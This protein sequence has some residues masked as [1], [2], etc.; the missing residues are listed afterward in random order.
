MRDGLDDRLMNIDTGWDRLDRIESLYGKD[1]ARKALHRA[2]NKKAKNARKVPAGYD[3]VLIIVSELFPLHQ[4]YSIWDGLDISPFRAVF[5]A[6]RRP[7]S[8]GYELEFELV[9]P[10]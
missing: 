4:W 2:I 5:I 8:K 10:S 1:D 6:N 3:Y 9:Q 7:D